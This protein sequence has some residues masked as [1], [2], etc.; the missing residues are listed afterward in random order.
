VNTDTAL[1]FIEDLG[2]AVARREKIV[3]VDIN[4]PGGAVFAGLAMVQA[5]RNAEQ[6]GTQT[7][8]RVDGLAA[9]MGFVLLQSCSFRVM[10][11]RSALMAHEVSV[12]E[13]GGKPGDLRRMAQRIEDI[14]HLLAIIECAR[15]NITLAEFEARIKDRDWFIGHEEALALGAV[16]L[17]VP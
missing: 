3:F 16:D 2:K 12:S 5:M 11:K 6:A 7:I 13:T 10:T 1:D 9:S 17:V 15:L 4:S 14:G 8:C